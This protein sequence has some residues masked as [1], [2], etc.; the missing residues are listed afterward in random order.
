LPGYFHTLQIPLLAG[1]DFNSSDRKSA[2]PAAIV[3]SSFARQFFPG[4]E[5]LG[6]RV[7]GFRTP[8]I[9]I[10]GICGDVLHVGLDQKSEAEIYFP[11]L[12]GSANSDALAVAIRTRDLSGMATAVR[13]AV[14][15]LDGG[16]PVFD[17]GPMEES[18]SASLATRRF[19]MLLLGVFAL[20]ALGLAA[21]GIY[22]VLSYAVAQRSQEIGIRVALG[23]TQ[24]RVLKLVLSEAAL[25][26]TAGMVLGVGGAL[27]LTRF[28][29][30]LLYKV[31]PT[32]P[33]T[34]IAV[35]ALLMITGLLAGFLPAHRASRVDPM[36]VLRAE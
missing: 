5:A 20:F 18:L 35:S 6:K 33:L 12:Q 3:N 32:D 13:K 27:S 19:S 1:R 21:L 23:S 29:A 34:L 25:L 14:K 15:A 8:W 24:G 10:V 4:E 9:T 30:G 26:T 7:R 31:K 16:Q 17:V 11:L 28:M 36:I 22:G 2:T